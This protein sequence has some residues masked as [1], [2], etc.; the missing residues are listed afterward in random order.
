MKRTTDLR[1]VPI[2]SKFT[3]PEAVALKLISKKRK[4]KRSSLI[5]EYVIRGLQT[6]AA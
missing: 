2:T 4:L 3:R 5:R 6:E 1:Q